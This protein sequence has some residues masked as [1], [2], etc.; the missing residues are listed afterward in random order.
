MVKLSYWLN[1]CRSDPE[2]VPP[3]AVTRPRA[4]SSFSWIPPNEPLDMTSRMSPA[5]ASRAPRPHRPPRPSSRRGRFRGAPFPA[6]TSSRSAPG[7]SSSPSRTWACSIPNQARR[8]WYGCRPAPH[9]RGRPVPFHGQPARPGPQLQESDALPVGDGQAGA[10]RGERLHGGAAGQA[11]DP[12]EP[13]S[14][15]TTARPRPSW[16]SRSGSHPPLPF[17]PP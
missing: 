1:P 12:T 17:L 9:D 3:W 11:R 8:A 14:T 2:G 10:R 6:R 5:P 7:G 15:R 4:A 13:D 16:W